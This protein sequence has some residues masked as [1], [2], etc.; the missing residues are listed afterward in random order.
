MMMTIFLQLV[1]HVGMSAKE[2]LRMEQQAK[3]FGYDH[4]DSEWHIP[5]DGVCI[6]G[7]L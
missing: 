5:A 3:N 1:V 2:S 4:N 6:P 7:K